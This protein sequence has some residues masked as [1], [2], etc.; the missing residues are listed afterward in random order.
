MR[1]VLAIIVSAMAMVMLST[2]PV[3]ALA[4][5]APAAPAVA[6]ASGT[7]IDV[8]WV[9]PGDG[10]SALTSF[11]IDVTPA[12]VGPITG[13]APAATTTEVTGLTAGTSYTFVVTAINADGSTSSPASAA[14][15]PDA[16]PSAPSAPLA[17]VA[18][19]TEVDVLWAAPANAGSSITSYTVTASPGGA[20]QTTA[21]GLSLLFAG[22]TPGT[23]YTFTV[24]ATNGAG[25]S[26]ESASSGSVTPAGAP[27]APAAPTAAPAT[28]TSVGVSWVAPASN[29]S[30]I[31]GYTVTAAP[32]GATQSAAGTSHT[33]TSLTPGTAYTFTVS[34]TNA[35]GTGSDS[36]A[37]NSVTPSAVPG[38]PGQPNVSV[39]SNTSIL[40]DWSAAAANGSAITGYSV[41]ASPGNVVQTTAGATTLSFTGL[42]TGTAYTFQVKA[43]NVNGTG[44]NGAASNSITPAG[45]PGAAGLPVATITSATSL[46]PSWTAAAS[47]GSAVSYEVTAFDGATGFASQVT[48]SLST[49]F[50][51]LTSG[52]AY[53][54]TVRPFNAIGTGPTT[55]KSAPVVVAGIPSKPAVPGISFDANVSLNSAGVTWVAPSANGSTITGYEVVINPGNI[56]VSATAG[57]TSAQVSPLNPGTY[58][59][60]VRAINAFGDGPLSDASTSIVVPD[61]P[62][63]VTNIQAVANEL[64]GNVVVISWDPPTEDGGSE[65]LSYTVKMAGVQATVAADVSSVAIGPLPSGFH[66][67]EINANTVAGEGPSLFSNQIEVR[68]F[69]P[70]NSKE[71]FVTQQYQ[72][73]LGRAP[74][75]AG[76]AFWSGQTAS[77][78][79]NVTN[80]IV[81][82]MRSPEFAPRRPVARLY[83]AYFERNPEPGGFDYWTGLLASGQTSLESISQEFS[84]SQEFINTYGTLSNADFVDLVYQNV[85]GRAGEAGGVAY[86]NGQLDGGLNRGTMMTLFSESAE[87]LNSTSALVDV[88]VTYRG[89]LNRLPDPSG[90]A[91]WTAQIAGNPDAI[92][93]LVGGFYISAE[94]GNR[95]TP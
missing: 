6:I 16:V 68:T 8:T 87:N 71:A 48:T 56:V 28:S 82:F 43:T 33:F 4:P 1:K 63:Q 27:D 65:V 22:L 60:R 17:T 91:Y 81:Q 7:S 18:S 45:V 59:A 44:A 49:T 74:D 21:M 13:I 3:F 67:A 20:T 32:G 36:A 9:I 80:T 70:F 72:D 41:T 30:A 54:F 42:T 58:T 88:I 25:N 23:A 77:D 57:A 89:M 39:E 11:T 76:L 93:S 34:A 64:Y 29:G 19:S 92:L 79:G 84:K 73:F 90:Q 35:I 5:D 37:S 26:A 51:G 24:F 78:R 47:N 15:T 31:T 55:A 38:A 62:G 53:T 14:I 83:L 46:T 50:T 94:Y 52:R 95:V 86:W 85:L 2:T 69:A 12:D 66:S 40:L 61:T 75:A 10:G